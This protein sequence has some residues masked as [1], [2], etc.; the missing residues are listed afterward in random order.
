[1]RAKPQE[2]QAG[3][4]ANLVQNYGAEVEEYKSLKLVS[5]E[6]EVS[7]Q[8]R[9]FL[10]VFKGKAGKPVSNYYYRSVF[11]R[12]TA[13]EGKKAMADRYEVRKAEMKKAPPSEAARCAIAIRTELKANFPGVKFRVRCD[14][15]SMGNSV[16]V[17]WTDGPTEEAINSLI[18]KYQ[19]G[20]FDGMVDM[21]ENSNYRDDIPQA[22]YVHG[23]REASDRTERFLKHWVAEN[24]SL[25]HVEEWQKQ[26]EM[27]RLYRAEFGKLS[28]PEKMFEM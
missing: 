17:N 16:D 13:V 6:S 24:F 3:F 8:K 2:V 18:R 19:Y 7:G 21:Y 5:Y 28:M 23:R 20:H 10:V 26:Q 11:E 12:A 14:N 25:N 27:N 15:F 1:M 4:V 9:P 22:K